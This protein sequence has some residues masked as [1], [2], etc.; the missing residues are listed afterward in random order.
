MLRRAMGADDVERLASHLTLVPPV[1]LRD[2]DMESG[3]DLLRDA[4]ERTSPF[5]L[6]LGPPRTSRPTMRWAR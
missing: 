6:K 4:A 2:D 3:L 5:L 1:N